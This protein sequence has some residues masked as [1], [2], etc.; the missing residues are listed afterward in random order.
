MKKQ[1]WLLVLGATL[2]VFC[3]FST[4]PS[5]EVTIRVA[6]QAS[7]WADAFKKFVPKFTEE[8]GIK[9]EFEDISFGVMYEKLKTTF[10]GGTSKVDMIWYDSMW[11][12]EFA[13]RGWIKD[14]SPYLKDS[15]LTPSNFGYPHDFFGTF[16]SGAYPAGNRWNLPEG[17]FGIPWIAGFRPLYYRSD[18]LKE[19]GFIDPFGEAKPPDTMDELLAYA[20]KINN[21]AKK[22]YG[23]VM[24]AKRPRIVYDW[25]GF[26]WTYGGEFFDKDFKPAFNSPAGIKALETYIELGKV[27]PPGVAAYH[28]TEAWTAFMQGQAALT[29]TWQDLASVARKESQIIGKFKC[30]PTPVYAGRRVPLVGGIVA[31]IPSNAPNAEAAYKF[32]MYAQMPD[33]AKAA[34]LMGATVQRRS[35]WDDPAV[36]EMYPSAVGDLEDFCQDSGRTVPLIPEWATVDQIIGEQISAAFVGQKSAKEALDNA[37]EKVEQFMQKAGYY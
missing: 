25:S 11:T 3:F 36:E 14:L 34:T 29:W 13:K 28:I 21:P 24:P 4:T 2:F 30:A 35:T 15:S 9:I 37:A 17:V 22:I 12:P 20:K 27:A 6:N 26:L 19:A 18:L 1:R 23:Y 31:S 33:N 5:A 8:T 16:Y 7:Q 32:I 10:I